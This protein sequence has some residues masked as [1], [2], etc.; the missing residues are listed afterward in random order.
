MTLIIILQKIKYRLFFISVSFHHVLVEKGGKH[1]CS[2]AIGLLAYQLGRPVGRTHVIFQ[3]VL[4]GVLPS[5]AKLLTE[6]S[7]LFPMNKLDVGQQILPNTKGFWTEA[8]F[9]PLPLQ[10]N[11]INMYIQLTLLSK[12]PIAAVFFAW[13]WP[14][15]QVNCV[16]MRNQGFLSGKH[17]IATI[18]VASEGPLLQMNLINMPFHGSLGYELGLTTVLSAREESPLQLNFIDMFLQ[19][20]VNKKPV[21]W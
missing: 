20:E 17:L 5:T 8:T 21:A 10:V 3:P 19:A 7:F 18:L 1:K 12:R 2:T 13:E 14:L 15:P 6:E 9:E 4:P 16:Y 11:L